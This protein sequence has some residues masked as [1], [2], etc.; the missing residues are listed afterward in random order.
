[1]YIYICIHIYVYIYT[2]THTHLYT[3]GRR[4]TRPSRRQQPRL[5]HRLA[6]QCHE[7]EEKKA[8]WRKSFKSTGPTAA[9]RE[10]CVFAG[11]HVPSISPSAR[12]G[13]SHVTNM[14]ESCHTYEWVMSQI[15]M[16]HVTYKWV[17]SFVFDGEHVLSIC[18]PARLGGWVVVCG[19]G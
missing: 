7:L 4:T 16:S 10:C 8:A 3:G 15:W 17:M 19:F 2:H 14:N 9:S 11:E 5:C 13:I 12:C 6:S 18:P 1:M